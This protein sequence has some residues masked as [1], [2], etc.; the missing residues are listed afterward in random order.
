MS[1][2]DVRWM[3]IAL[4][5]ARA[6]AAMGDVPVGAVIVD[7]AGNLLSRG[8]NRRELDRDPKRSPPRAFSAQASNLKTQLVEPQ[9]DVIEQPVDAMALASVE[10]LFELMDG[11]K[12]P[13]APLR[14]VFPAR[15]VTRGSCA[16][17][18]ER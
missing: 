9:I 17:P 2:L 4:E 18:A 13:A 3:Q 1:E 8:R 5:E 16:P 10:I 11:P 6:A 7:S 15:L 12:R 14:R